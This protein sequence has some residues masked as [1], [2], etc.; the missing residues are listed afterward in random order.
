MKLIRGLH[1]LARHQPEFAQGCVLTIGNFD[2]VHLGHRAIL[3]QVHQL[4][5][6]RQLPSV[7]MIFE[8]LPIEYFS[9]KDAPV[10]LM[11]LREKLAAFQ[12]TDIDYVVVCRFDATFANLSA[13]AFV[14]TILH[15]G[16]NAKQVVVGDDFRFGKA[17]QGDFNLL[18]QYGRQL[19]FDTLDLMTY[20]VDGERVSST[21]IRQALIR[22]DLKAANRLLGAPFSFQG[23]VIH[24]QKLGRKIGFRTLNLNPKRI[25]MPLEGVYS[26][27]VTGLAETDWPGVANIGIRPT[28]DGHRPSIEVHLFNWQKDVYGA[29]IGVKISQFI[30]PELKFDGI[31]A[32]KAQIEKDVVVAQVHHGL[33]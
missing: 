33:L 10:R 5:T 24:G 31:D 6:E 17:R 30:R 29:H 27:S 20:Q 14:K 25:Q 9:P 7:V 18:Q 12:A 16:L 13:E 1:N 4:A 26:V 22:Q 23:R 28:V 21:R 15:Q 3:S 32:L 11:N 19:G 2:G 8:P